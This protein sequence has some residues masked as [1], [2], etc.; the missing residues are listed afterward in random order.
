M[1]RGPKEALPILGSKEICPRCGRPATFQVPGDKKLRCARYASQC[2]AVRELNSKM[3]A[4]A[5]EQGRKTTK[6]TNEQRSKGRAGKR[7]AVF[8]RPG[9]GAF[10]SAL[11]LERGHRCE[12]CDLTEWLLQPITLELEHTDGDRQNNTRENLLLLCPNCHS[13]TPTWRGRN[14]NKQRMVSDQELMAA[15]DTE[16]TIHKALMKVGMTAKGANYQRC[17]ALQK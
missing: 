10:K 14:R 6:F 16:P 12:K 2:P 13:L 1:R 3:L 8:G 4:E 7:F 9:H 17:R 15:L 11:I 5:Y